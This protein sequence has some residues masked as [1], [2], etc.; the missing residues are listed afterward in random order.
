MNY[1]L[2]LALIR[3]AFAIAFI[4]ALGGCTRK[5]DLSPPPLNPSP[6]NVLQISIEADST[7]RYT[8]KIVAQ[9]GNLSGD[10]GYVDYGK[11]LGGAMVVPTAD[12]PIDQVDDAFPV[13]LDRYAEQIEC[14]WKLLGLGIDVVAPNGRVAFSGLSSRDLRVGARKEV[15]CN[16][17]RPDVNSCLAGA[18]HMSGPGV[19]VTISVH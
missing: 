18:K 6:S 3:T 13:Y 10:C 4:G 16:F 2:H 14:L 5:K 17:S 15:M 7:S 1:S 11:A 12:I 8:A 9:Y 19:K